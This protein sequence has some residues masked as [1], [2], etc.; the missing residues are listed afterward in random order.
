MF[1]FIKISQYLDKRLMNEKKN[2]H[3]DDGYP[4]Y[5]DSGIRKGDSDLSV[6]VRGHD[7]HNL[8]SSI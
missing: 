7:P 6:R 8:M 2:Q 1:C 4:Y 5:D 3:L